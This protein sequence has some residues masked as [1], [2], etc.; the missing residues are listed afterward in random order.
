MMS[1]NATLVNNTNLNQYTHT[2][3]GKLSTTEK[4][5]DHLENSEFV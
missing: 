5:W 2:L 4:N 3:L 1:N